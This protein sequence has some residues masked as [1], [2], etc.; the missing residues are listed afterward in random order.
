[1]KELWELQPHLLALIVIAIGVKVSFIEGNLKSKLLLL[2]IE[3]V[4][5]PTGLLVAI[6]TEWA[7][8]GSHE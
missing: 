3:E 4:I 1:M 8:F 2:V 5:I 7:T 6:A